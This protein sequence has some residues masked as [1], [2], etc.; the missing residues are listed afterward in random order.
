MIRPDV[1]ITLRPYKIYK[2]DH[3][4]D[5]PVGYGNDK[6]GK[7]LKFQVL[8]IN[9]GEKGKLTG[10]AYLNVYTDIPLKIN[11]VVTVDKILYVQVKRMGYRTV[12][13]IGITIKQTSPNVIQDN[14]KDEDEFVMPSFGLDD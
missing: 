2:D 4:K 3:S 5:V 1:N 8:D 6:R 13:V 9:T 14:I 11:D 12:T 7:Y 10:F